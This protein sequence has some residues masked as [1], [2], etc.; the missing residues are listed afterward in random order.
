MCRLDPR[1]LA[2]IVRNLLAYALG[3]MSRGEVVVRN[4]VYNEMIVVDISDNGSVVSMTELEGLFQGPDKD[5][6]SGP[7]S[8]L[9]LY[10]ARAMAESVGG[11]VQAR[12][13]SGRGLTLFAELPLDA[14]Q[15][16]RR[17]S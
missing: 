6:R 15:P 3:R 5:G 11:R 9:G 13:S 12:Q 10:V 2:R 4:G 17:D 8:G 7:G 16:S 1:H 14:T